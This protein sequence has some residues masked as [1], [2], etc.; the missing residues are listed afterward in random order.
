M[1]AVPVVLDALLAAFTSALP[2]VQVVDGP[3]VQS[4]AGDVVAVGMPPQERSPGADSTENIA[5]MSAIEEAI[6]VNCL[7]RSWSGSDGV[8]AQRDRTAGFVVALR[9]HLRADTTLGDV[10]GHARITGSSYVPWR[11]DGAR[12]IVDFPFR[13]E[14]RVITT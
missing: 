8:K 12:L 13:V 14:V 11:D 3:P 10:V 7:A 2:G 1:T 5:G 4:I 6:V 9:A